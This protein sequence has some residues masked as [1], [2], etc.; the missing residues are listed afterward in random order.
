[1]CFNVCP[2]REVN[3]KEISGSMAGNVQNDILIG[4]YQN[5]YTGY[6]TDD[7]MRYSSASGGLA[8]QLLV[9]ALETGRIDGALVTRMRK[10]YPLIPEPFIARTKEEI[11]EA[12][13]SKYCPVPAN[14]ALKTIIKEKGHFAVVGL[15]CHMH[16]IRK[17]EQFNPSLKDKIVLHIGIICGH[18]PNF[19]ST[20]IFLSRTG[21]PVDEVSQINYRGEGWPGNVV[22]NKKDGG[23]YPLPL[24][25]YY[26]V[27]GM[28]FYQPA[29][30]LVC[31]DMM[32]EL[33]D[34]SCGDAW[35]E[36]NDDKQGRSI[37]IVRSPSGKSM[38]DCALDNGAV[39][40]TPADAALVKRSQRNALY[41]KKKL[42]KAHMA[43]SRIN[44]DYKTNLLEPDVSDYLLAA[45]IQ[46]CHLF[47]TNSV[48]RFIL[49]RLSLKSLNRSQLPYAI[50]MPR[51]IIGF[52]RWMKP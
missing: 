38:V 42:V 16:G 1:M 27:Y 49:K 14:I 47:S 12:A 5:C 31:C 24:S 36:Y 7:I 45:V 9:T 25:S 39:E 21:I 6:S 20:R 29:R 11:I 26:S 52:Q 40:L 33:A 28:P 22:V 8:T 43:L 35:G 37:L 34:L 23:R 17:A 4:D 10:D 3:F 46:L 32:A 44:P 13:R 41:E 18:C 30:C 51:Q 48:L 50:I 15:P 19:W 2:G